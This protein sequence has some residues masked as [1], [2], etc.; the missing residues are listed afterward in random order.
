M[1]A[2]SAPQA[3]PGELQ[4]A[5]GALIWKD[6]G[7]ILDAVSR[8]RGTAAAIECTLRGASMG[9]AIPAG[10]RLR[11]DLGRGAPYRVGEVVA[12]VRGSGI[13]VHRVAYL[14]Q[15]PRASDQLV[16]Q[17]DACFYPDAPVAAR[18]VLGPVTELDDGAGWRPVAG[19]SSRD[20]SQ[21]AIGRAL[22]GALSAL[23]ELNVPLARCA[24]RVLR[25]RKESAARG[26]PI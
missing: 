2:P 15:G 4:R 12:F 1:S 14:G 21:S 17:G 11:I 24:A 13:C 23:T 20:R 22:L 6:P 9:A 7:R 8:L 16:T 10:A 26:A 19:P 5:V 25:L 3:D 18:C